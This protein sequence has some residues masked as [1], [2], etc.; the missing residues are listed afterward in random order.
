MKSQSPPGSAKLHV[1]IATQTTN[2]KGLWC[3]YDMIVLL[4]A[5][6]LNKAGN[7]AALVT[8]IST[9]RKVYILLHR[10]EL[11]FLYNTCWL[12]DFEIG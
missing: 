1:G 12:M 10:I 8:T 2:F 7:H 5:V 3:H 11:L 4:H 9:L 6:T